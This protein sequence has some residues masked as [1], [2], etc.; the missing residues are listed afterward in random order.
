MSKPLKMEK[1][2]YIAPE[3]WNVDITDDIIYKCTHEELDNNDFLVLPI[4]S[5]IYNNNHRIVTITYQHYIL[6]IIYSKLTLFKLRKILKNVSNCYYGLC[7]LYNIENNDRN[8]LTIEYYLTPFKKVLEI[9][10]DD[11]EWINKIHINSGSYY[12]NVIKIWREEEYCKVL[13]HELIHYFKLENNYNLNI[14]NNPI[15]VNNNKYQI[16]NEL[17]TELQTW[18]AYQTI[19]GLHYEEEKKYSISLAHLILSKFKINDNEYFIKS[20]TSV[21]MYYVYKGLMFEFLSDEILYN[22]MLPM[23]DSKNKIKTVTLDLINLKTNNYIHN[24]YS[25]KMMKY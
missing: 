23:Y 25:L 24:T 19:F 18:I 4:A 15:K 21:L 13:I 17:K 16:E 12:N 20:N 8:M 6:K 22:I 5:Y 14:I 2:K 11:D 3:E 9:T 10:S 7:S 1:G